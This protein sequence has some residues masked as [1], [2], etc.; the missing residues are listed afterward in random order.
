MKTLLSI[1]AHAEASDAVA[2]HWKYWK[3]SGCDILGLSPLD[4]PCRW[5]EKIPTHNFGN[6]GREGVNIIERF[7]DAFLTLGYCDQEGFDQ[8]ILIEYDVV[9]FG[10]LNLR[11]YPP[12]QIACERGHNTDA[13]FQAATYC[14]PPVIMTPTVMMEIG[15][16]MKRMARKGQI[17]HGCADRMIGLAVQHLGLVAEQVPGCMT[18]DFRHADPVTREQRFEQARA[19]LKRGELRFCHMIKTAEEL[20]RLVGP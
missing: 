6:R 12:V 16:E 4:A 3:Q 8:I 13:K 11:E 15:G 10:K 20:E 1:M 18:C 14:L 7:I 5:P 17:E 9:T 2:R 19:M